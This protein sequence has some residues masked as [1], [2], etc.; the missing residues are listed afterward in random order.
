MKVVL[1]KDEK[2]LGVIGDVVEVKPGYANNYLFPQGIAVD[3][4]PEMIEKAQKNMIKKR[5]EKKK[6]EKKVANAGTILKNKKIKYSVKT[7]SGGRTF[8]SI[9]KEDI[10]KHLAKELKMKGSKF[11]VDLSQPIKE[12]GKYALGVK[13]ETGEKKIS[14]DIILEV[15]SE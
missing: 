14:T 2:S 8:G 11:D 1:I 3:G 4:T 7:S 15:V 12:V 5:E 6:K 10:E 13:I 9:S